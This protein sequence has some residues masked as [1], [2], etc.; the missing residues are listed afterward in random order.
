MVIVR[1][2]CLSAADPPGR[3]APLPWSP[4]RA[5]PKLSRPLKAADRIR[6]DR[7][8]R[9][10]S[11][12]RNFSR[13]PA[14]WQAAGTMAVP[15]NLHGGDET[16]GA[17]VLLRWMR[18]APTAKSR[19]TSRDTPGIGARIATSDSPI[20]S[21]TRLA[22]ASRC[23]GGRARPPIFPAT[24]TSASQGSPDGHAM[25]WATDSF[26]PSFCWRLQP[27]RNPAPRCE[28]RNVQGSNDASDWLNPPDL[29]FRA[30]RRVRVWPRLWPFRE[31]P[32]L[33]T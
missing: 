4:V 5:V 22:R 14:K 8:G 18:T 13:P 29:R 19:P 21:A 16:R 30:R 25:T 33:T 6:A 10:G 2:S 15:S 23:R 28:T 7:R 27:T 3:C 9:A 17:V 32:A 26:N 31:S 11:S 12:G 1:R 24:R 20:S